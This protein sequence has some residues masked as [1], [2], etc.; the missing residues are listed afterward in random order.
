MIR[1]D[2]PHIEKWYLRLYW[3][4]PAFQKW[5]NFEYIKKGYYAAMHKRVASA[6]SLFILPLGPLPAINKLHNK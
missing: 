6:D 4:R 2:F 3:D 1:N 5:T